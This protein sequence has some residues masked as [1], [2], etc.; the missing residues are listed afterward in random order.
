[1]KSRGLVLILKSHRE[2]F[3]DLIQI[4]ARIPPWKHAYQARKEFL[5]HHPIA[6]LQNHALA[7]ECIMTS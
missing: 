2:I 3:E 6:L 7:A 1:M 5:F 4:Y